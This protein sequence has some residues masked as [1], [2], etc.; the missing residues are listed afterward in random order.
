[1]PK[2]TDDI[3]IFLR[4]L[5]PG[6]I[7]ANV[8][9]INLLVD[10][11]IMSLIPGAVSALYYAD[12]VNQL[13]LAM[14]GIAIGTALLP[15]LSRKI[16]SGDIKSAIK[17]Q[18]AALEISLILSIPA[19]LALTCLAHPII[20][21]LF[22]RGNFQ[23]KDT[24]LVSTALK[25]YSVGLPAYIAVK[26]LEPSFFSRGNTK[27]P[28]KIAIK[29]LITNVIL[30]LLFFKPFGYIGIVLASVISSYLNVTLLLKNLTRKE[31]FAFEK[32]FLKTILKISF[33]AIAMAT[34]ILL[35]NH[36]LNNFTN[37]TSISKLSI[38]ISFGLIIYL[39]ITYLTGVLDI[40]LI[41]L[42]PRK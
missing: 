7:G 3:K 19:T 13:P 38:I 10:T 26:V 33:C 11:I 9:Q 12:H 17:L 40:L 27:I 31:Y 8:M 22:Q 16:K 30:N 24:D 34:T 29:C 39:S 28:M 41:N 5:I 23:A 42:K 2:I 25:F 35:L 18:N 37:L 1:M 15:A 32:N 14:I 4:K 21:V 20:E 36:Y 6:I